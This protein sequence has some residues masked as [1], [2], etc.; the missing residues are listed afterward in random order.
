MALTGGKVTKYAVARGNTI[1]SDGYAKPEQAQQQH[2]HLCEQMTTL[3]L[4]PDLDVVEVTVTTTLS[5][6]KVHR[7][8]ADVDITATIE[9]ATIPTDEGE[10]ASESPRP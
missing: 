7:D 9:T 5:K 3:G 1:I 6:P 4:T 10:G 2:T 8:H